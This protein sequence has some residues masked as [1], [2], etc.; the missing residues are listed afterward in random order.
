MA[1]IVAMLGGALLV[2]YLR[3]FEEEKSGGEPVELLAAVKPLAAGELITE[4]KLAT[5]VVPR[6]YVED[7]AVLAAERGKII[8]LRLGHT[9]QAQQMLMWT[10]LNIALEE[11]R[12]L[13]QLVQPGMRAVTVRAGDSDLEKSFALIRPGD[14]VDVLL[15]V[16]G[17]VQIPGTPPVQRTAIVLLQ[18]VL[19][20][21]VGTDTGAESGR[22]PLGDNERQD[23][24]LSLS[25]NV[26]EAQLLTLATEKGNIAVALRNPDD[27]LVTEGISDVND[28]ALQDVRQRTQVT[29]VRRGSVRPTEIKTPEP[30]R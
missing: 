27:V 7:R 26:P 19:V 5:R 11:R 13:S 12:N 10:D 28:I 1:L 21:A 20:L 3:R 9:L 29:N 15:T 24:I 4:D 6:A 17:G 2:F 14:R 23:I 30:Q 25:L 16:A 8:G 22:G 18:N